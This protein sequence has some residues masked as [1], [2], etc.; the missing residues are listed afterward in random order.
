MKISVS[1][2]EKKMQS[3]LKSG[4]YCTKNEDGTYDVA[5]PF[6]GLKENESYFTYF[7]SKNGEVMLTGEGYIGLSQSHA[8]K[9]V[10]ERAV[11]EVIMLEQNNNHNAKAVGNISEEVKQIVKA[12]G[13][14]AVG[15]LLEGNFFVVKKGKNYHVGFLM[16]KT[17]F[18][19]HA[20]SCQEEAESSAYV[21][22]KWPMQK[23]D[24]MPCNQRL[25]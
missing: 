16:G 4:A 24:M 7:K 10:K 8:R 23:E 3:V 13:Y 19:S 17:L 6:S 9:L 12:K 5:V 25:N 2:T 21:F 11:P 1:L 14:V 22:Y 15:D 20:E 18:I